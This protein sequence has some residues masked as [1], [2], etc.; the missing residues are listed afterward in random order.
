MTTTP[1]AVRRQINDTINSILQNM[2]KMLEKYNL[3]SVTLFND[4]DKK[5]YADEYYSYFKNIPFCLIYQVR[6]LAEILFYRIYYSLSL[7]ATEATKKRRNLK[8][9]LASPS[10]P[11]DQAPHF[12]Q[13]NQ[14][15]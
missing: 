13:Y 10:C 9:I 14:I 1:I 7:Q 11:N 3:S 12:P 15:Q 8:I 5:L 2:V 6:S 4:N